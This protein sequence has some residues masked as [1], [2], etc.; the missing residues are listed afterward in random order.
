M[1]IA[2]QRKTF[3]YSPPKP[4][5]PDTLKTEVETQSEALM[6]EFLKPQFIKPSI[7]KK[8]LWIEK[9]ANDG[10]GLELDQLLG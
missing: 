2:K 3:V 9:S 1:L 7:P 6:G 10:A 5:V 8:S 4:P